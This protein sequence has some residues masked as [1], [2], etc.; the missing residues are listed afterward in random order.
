[1]T[2]V[3]KPSVRSCETCWILRLYINTAMILLHK[4]NLFDSAFIKKSMQ[5]RYTH[6]KSSWDGKPLLFTQGFLI[7][8][9]YLFITECPLILFSLQITLNNCSIEFRGAQF[10]VCDRGKWCFLEFTETFWDIVF[11]Q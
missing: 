8:V 9:N 3:L 1:M 10:G 7:L 4:S 6:S 11:R 5:H 2:T